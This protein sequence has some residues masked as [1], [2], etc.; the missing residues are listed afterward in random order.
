[1]GEIT[2]CLNSH[3]E[4]PGGWGTVIR[5]AQPHRGR[6]GCGREPDWSEGSVVLCQGHG[7]GEEY[8]PQDDVGLS[9]WALCCGQA[10]WGGVGRLLG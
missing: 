3:E 9:H 5:T 4:G 8:L 2:A 7:A 1:M 10:S 6:K